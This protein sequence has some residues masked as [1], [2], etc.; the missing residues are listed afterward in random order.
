MALIPVIARFVTTPIGNML[1]A[2]DGRG[3]SACL[4]RL[5]HSDWDAQ[6]KAHKLIACSHYTDAACSVLDVAEQQISDYFA[7]VRQQFDLPLSL[8]G[9]PFQ[10]QVWRAINNIPYAKTRS[11]RD[12]CIAIGRPAAARALGNACGRN[13]V[14]LIIP[15]H[16]VIQTNGSIG[17]F[18]RST[19]ISVDIKRSLLAFEAEHV[20]CKEK[21]AA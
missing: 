3:L 5:P 18:A 12:L 19:G 6:L 17:G 8:H 13:P 2:S 4:Y 1:I 10:Q 16:R 14:G 21:I 7:G 9:T 20:Q 11:Y 15:C